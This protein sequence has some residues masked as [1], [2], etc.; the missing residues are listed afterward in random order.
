MWINIIVTVGLAVLIAIAYF[1]DPKEPNNAM[2]VTRGCVIVP[3]LATALIVFWIAR[4]GVWFL[5]TWMKRM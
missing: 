2:G 3:L 1:T 4:L 5:S